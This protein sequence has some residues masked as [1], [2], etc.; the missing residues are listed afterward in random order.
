MKKLVILITVLFVIT[1]LVA[2]VR[3]IVPTRSSTNQERY[4][5]RDVFYTEDFESGATGWTHYD[6][7]VTPN[8]WHIYNYGGTQGDVWWMGDPALATD[9]YIGG[10]HDHQ[11][12]VLNTP[13]IALTSGNSTLTFKMR[14]N[15]EEPGVSGEFNG[16]DSFNLRVSTNNG[17]SYTVIPTTL[18]TPGYDF[19]SSYAFGSEHG[20]TP[21]VPAWGGVHEPWVTVTVN[22]SSYVGQSV[23]IRFA[24]ASDP[25]YSTVDDPQ[26]YGVM[27]DDITLGSYT[28]NGVNDGQMTWA[29]MVPTAGDFWHLATDPAAPSPTHIMSSMNSANTYAPNMLDYL[30]SPT[31]N[32]PQDATQIVADF[33]LRGTYDDLDT[34]PNV[35]YFGWEISIDGGTSWRYMSNPYQDPDLSN[36]VYSG[37]PAIFSSFINSYADVTGDITLFAGLPVKFRWYFQSDGDTPIGTPLQIDNFQIF[38]VTAAPAPVNL[39][40]PTN[41]QTGLSFTGFVFD[42]SPSSLGAPPEYYVLFI[43][44]EEANLEVATFSPSYQSAEITT[45]YINSNDIPDLVLGSNQTWYWRVAAYV[46]GQTESYSEIY[47]F[48]TLATSSVITTF[49]WTEGFEG[50]TFPPTGWTV[51]NV[52]GG[53]N[54]WTVNTTAAYVHSGTKSA[55]HAYGIAI[56]DPGENGWLISPP[57]QLPATGVGGLT[58]WNYNRYGYE[59]YNGLLINTDPNPMD[60]YWVELWTQDETP[61]AWAQETIN[62]EDYMGQIVYFAFKYTGYDANNWYIDDVNLAI[63]T[64]DVFAPV[65]SNHLPLINTPREDLARLVTVDVVDD[66]VFNNPISAVNLYWSLDGGTNWSSAIPMTISTGNTYQGTLPAQPLGSTVTYKIE[67]FD[68]YNNMASLSYSYEVD[69]P[70][71]MWYDQGGTGYTGFPTYNWGP[72]VYYAN[73]FYQTDTAVKLL[74][75]DGA[76]YNSNTGNGPTTATMHIYG[77]DGVNMF[78]LMTPISVTFNHATYRTIDLSAYNLQITTPWFWISYEN[79]GTGRYFLYDS[80]FNYTDPLLL[81]IGGQMASSSSPGEWCIGAYVQTGEAALYFPPEP[82]IALNAGGQPQVSWSA[83]TGA[84]SYDVY[85]CNDPYATF[86]DEWTLLADNITTTSYTYNGT[87]PMQFFKVIASTNAGGGKSMS[88]GPSAPRIVN[89]PKITVPTQ[90]IKADFAPQKLNRK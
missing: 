6:G 63:Y 72:I 77:D 85:G 33:Q 36:Y 62:L 4:P 60:P 76:L 15:M 44:Q 26:M 81:M 52:D 86:P 46:T 66:A 69:D 57:V 3:N 74:A 75:T 89:A 11:Y 24:F 54:T 1:G 61:G 43:D 32:L 12:L 2:G 67:A 23:K 42:W 47:R 84:A 9:S 29:S 70:V 5:N 30:V 19:T 87:A 88:I 55:V 14:T 40:Y 73:P 83:L 22:L 71:W 18:I 45:S 68:S 64:S 80:R 48:T 38:S 20:E 28:N 65:L 56:P 7:A 50:S 8:N 17:L 35:D 49:P 37:G 78:D 51:A 79:L 90:T 27:V 41:G 39:V 58:F 82:V 10:Y 13:Q 16:W 34:F 25:A 53:G 59:V 21:P 31:I